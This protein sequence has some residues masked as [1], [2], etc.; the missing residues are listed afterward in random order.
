MVDPKYFDDQVGEPNSLPIQFAHLTGFYQVD[1][2][3]STCLDHFVNLRLECGEPII[4][5]R[6]IQVREQPGEDVQAPT[7]VVEYFDEVSP[8]DRRSS[9]AC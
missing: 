8:L 5:S 6:A 3:L 4:V 2:L 1:R 9:A 7:F